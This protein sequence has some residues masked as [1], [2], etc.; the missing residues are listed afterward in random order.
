MFQLSYAILGEDSPTVFKRANFN[1]AKPPDF[2]AGPTRFHHIGWFNR[3]VF[4]R[5][6]S[7]SGEVADKVEIAV[8]AGSCKLDPGTLPR[9]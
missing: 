5:N 4:Q 2:P 8:G 6:D 7:F 1:I 9:K 3:P